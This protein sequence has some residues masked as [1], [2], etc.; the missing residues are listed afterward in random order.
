M[1]LPTQIQTGDRF[2]DEAGEWKVFSRS[3][4]TNAVKDAP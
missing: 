2:V 1:V 4:V 3:Y